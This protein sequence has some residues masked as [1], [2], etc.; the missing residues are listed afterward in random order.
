MSKM[1]TMRLRQCG[2]P[3]YP[4]TSKRL[5]LIGARALRANLKR[6]M[7]GD[8]ALVVGTPGAAK[9][10]IVPVPVGEWHRRFGSEKRRM[11]TRQRFEEV[12]AILER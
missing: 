1:T 6:I 8:R 9:C 4:A 3:D 10:I 5:P 11:G 7:E 2:Y 12:M